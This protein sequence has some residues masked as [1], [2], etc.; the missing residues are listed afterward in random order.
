MT[1]ENVKQ[2]ILDRCMKQ[3]TAISAEFAI[4]IAGQK[5]GTLE[6][7]EA[8]T[9]SKR[10]RNANRW[11]A[12]S[13]EIRERLSRMHPC[14]VEVFKMPEG[15]SIADFQ[16][17]VSNQAAKLFGKGEDFYSTAQTNDKNGIEVIR[18]A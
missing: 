5:Y 18:I 16:S 6:I 8:E 1:I 9:K 17:H 2:N 10:T 11:S 15:E 4:V 13:A 3:L 14:D 7:A 12:V